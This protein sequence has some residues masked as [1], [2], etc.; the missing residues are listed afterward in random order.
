MSL[1]SNNS[2]FVLQYSETHIDLAQSKNVYKHSQS[3]LV[4]YGLTQFT[5]SYCLELNDFR[6]LRR[7]YLQIMHHQL[8]NS[9]NIHSIRRASILNQ[10]ALKINSDQNSLKTYSIHLKFTQYT[11]KIHHIKDQSN[12]IIQFSQYSLIFVYYIANNNL[13]VLK[14]YQRTF[15]LGIS[16]PS[17]ICTDGVQAVQ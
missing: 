14:F 10:N 6:F 13:L 2:L 4:L 16:G 8:K 5:T 15:W 7:Q 11:L 9:L 1:E 3:V 17:K 12:S